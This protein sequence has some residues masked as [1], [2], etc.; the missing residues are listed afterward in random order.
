MATTSHYQLADS[1]E[2]EALGRD[3]DPANDTSAALD[4]DE[5]VQIAPA[6]T[7]DSPS[8][9]TRCV[10][11]CVVI[12]TVAGGAIFLSL[13]F[14]IHRIGNR[15]NGEDTGPSNS[16]APTS[17]N[18]TKVTPIPKPPA[19]SAP[20]PPTDA[21]V[22]IHT[23]KVLESL[24]HD[25]RAFT[26]GFEFANGVFYEG[27]GLHGQ[28]TLRKVE[29]QTGKVLQKYIYNN[30]TLFGEGITLHR[31]AHIFMLT[32]Q[33]GRGF[34]FN[35]STFEVVREWRYK[36]EG[37]G[38]TSDR[39]ADEVY[40]SDGTSNLRVLD[41]EDLSEKRTVKVTLRGEDV[42][43]LNELEWVCGEVWANIWQSNNIYRIDPKS[44]AVKSIIDASNLPLRTDM[45]IGLGVLNG[46]AFD[47][48]AG[49]LWLTGKLWSKVYSVSLSDTSLNLKNCK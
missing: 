4:P 12:L 48:E 22:E 14:G 28:S 6:G 18:A 49:R 31:D 16:S 38:L 2:L 35:Q 33:S 1:D 36:G 32:W 29:L 43:Y 47:K 19:L 44:G 20:I 23:V 10:C 25:Q 13:F 37:W 34:V 11:I 5:E 41:P 8:K 9:R 24:P 26:Q 17:S 27:T 42:K 39:E 46:I 7:D 21:K 15:S 40:M 30:M 3:N 45:Y